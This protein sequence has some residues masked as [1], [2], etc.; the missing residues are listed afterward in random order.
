MPWLKD[1]RNVDARAQAANEST[2]DLFVKTKT[3][4]QLHEQN[5]E[6]VTKARNLGHETIE[7]GV[8]IVQT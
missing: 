3:R 4:R 8:T 6:F 7:Q 2:G 5:A 1:G